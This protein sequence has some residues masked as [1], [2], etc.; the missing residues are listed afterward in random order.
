MTCEIHMIGFVWF[1]IQ[2]ND[3]TV[4]MISSIYWAK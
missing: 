1:K 2:T 3:I 4:V